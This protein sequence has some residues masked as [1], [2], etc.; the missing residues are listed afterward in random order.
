MALVTTNP[1]RLKARMPWRQDGQSAPVCNLRLEAE[2]LAALAVWW[3][4]A[5]KI[6]VISRRTG[7]RDVLTPN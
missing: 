7:I 1:G 2:H 5:G 4:G 6:A 3:L